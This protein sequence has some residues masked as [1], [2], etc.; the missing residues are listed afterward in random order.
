MKQYDVQKNNIYLAVAGAGKTTR[1]VK[2]SIEMHCQKKIAIL[3]YTNRAVLSIIDKLRSESGYGILPENVV[4]Y[5]WYNFLY[6]ECV[7][8]YQK[9]KFCDV[10]I[11]GLSFDGFY[12]KYSYFKKTDYKRYIN[13]QSQLRAKYAAD[14]VVEILKKDNS[15][16][17]RLEQIFEEIIVDEIQDLA[18]EDLDFITALLDSKIKITLVGDSRQ[19]T[20]VTHTSQRNKKYKGI[21][22]IDYFKILEASGKIQLNSWIEC[23]RSNQSICN[24]ADKL[25]PDLPQAVSKMEIK[26]CHD[27]V[28][29]IPI[30]HLSD[31]VRYLESIGGT[32]EFLRYDKKTK[33]DPYCAC[34]FG[35]CKGLTFDR[36]IVFPN[37][38]LY[39]YI[40]TFK[41]SAPAKYYVAL[42]RAR[43]SVAIMM[44]VLPEN[45][46]YEDV[47]IKYEDIIIKAKQF[48]LLVT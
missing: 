8:P 27:G 35:E 37:A 4:V 39:E 42:T 19:A 2:K 7:L 38:R 23:Y 15:L 46:L 30:E 10:D 22:I 28:F 36:V 16:I 11:K 20:F 32:Y 26:T 47:L 12:E 34:N 48:K 5:T 45:A 9:V 40:N 29:L 3:T 13:S 33:T 24:F 1:I 41:C 25:F 18:G 6:H 21:K 43:Y 31:Y 14:F 44:D 17:N